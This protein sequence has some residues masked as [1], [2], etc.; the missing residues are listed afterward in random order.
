[1]RDVPSQFS[2]FVTEFMFF[3]YFGIPNSIIAISDSPYLTALN[4]AILKLGIRGELNELKQ[5]WWED[6]NNAAM[7]EVS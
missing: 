7:C 2:A 6:L 3:F 5:K 4:K 1:M